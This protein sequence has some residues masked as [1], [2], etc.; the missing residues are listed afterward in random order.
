VRD[1]IIL[2]DNERRCKVT[3]K[4]V[5]NLLNPTRSRIFFEINASGETTTKKLLKKFPD[6]A[7]PTLYRHVKALLDSGM[8]KVTGQKQM[9]G[10][11][12]KTYAVNDNIGADIGQ[13]IEA[14]DGEG[15]FRLFS[16]YMMGV[17]GQFKSYCE[18]ENINIATDM[19]GFATA[20]LYATPAEMLEA[21]TKISEIMMPLV[22]NE[23]TAERKLYN[24]CTIVIPPKQ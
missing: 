3:S 6:I 5:D 22:T 4:V 12:E 19:A 7:Q 11:V 8:I 20:P 24:L 13:I 16:Q 15:F 14:N 23:H 2:Q 21:M 1:N 10:A 17:A 18:S 9:R